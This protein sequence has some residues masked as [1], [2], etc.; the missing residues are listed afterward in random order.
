[1]VRRAAF[2]SL[3]GFN[4]GLG[5][6]CEDWEFFFRLASASPVVKVKDNLMRYHYQPA[7]ASRQWKR[8]LE[9]ELSIEETMLSGT[10]GLDRAVARCR[11]RAAAYYRAAVGS[12]D[13]GQPGAAHVLRSLGYWPSFGFLPK[14]FKILGVEL[15][16][17]ARLR[18]RG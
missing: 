3:G 15:A 14:R 12:R 5:A 13:C 18:H 9:K 8:M 10:T 2:L 16:E 7:S 6:S 17:L 4:E 1:M 11:F